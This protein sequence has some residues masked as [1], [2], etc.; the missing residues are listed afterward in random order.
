VITI[1]ELSRLKFRKSGFLPEMAT[2]RIANDVETQVRDSRFPIV[3][4][5][6]ANAS[7]RWTPVAGFL[8]GAV[9]AILLI[10][11]T[12]HCIRA[13]IA[14]LHVARS[15]RQEVRIRA[16]SI[17]SNS[18]SRGHTP[19]SSTST[20]ASRPPRILVSGREIEP[21]RQRAPDM[22]VR[23]GNWPTAA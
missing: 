23:R 9:I 12:I 7:D 13:A 20:T 3:P 6:A 16:E 15:R 10:G 22:T 5:L 8:A 19:C 1:S 2:T 11:A 18:V 4:G 14:E 17:L 21:G